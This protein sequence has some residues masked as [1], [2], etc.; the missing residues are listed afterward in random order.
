MSIK[1]YQLQQ[2]GYFIST[3]IQCVTICKALGV[4]V[5]VSD[6]MGDVFARCSPNHVVLNFENSVERNRFCLAKF[7]IRAT[8]MGDLDFEIRI[9]D[10]LP[11]SENIKAI[12]L[13]IPSKTLEYAIGELGIKN[14]S[15]LA[16]HFSVSEK[17]MALKIE[18]LRSDR[19]HTL[20]G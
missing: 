2:A 20:K 5:S 4:D 13:L 12:D 3:P 8:E 18:M 10:C 19:Q 14:V 16:D 1:L 11:D 6:G 9:A 15:E 7:I 17:A